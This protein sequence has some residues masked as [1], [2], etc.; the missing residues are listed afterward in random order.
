M[1]QV[2]TPEE[3]DPKILEYAAGQIVEIS[4]TLTRYQV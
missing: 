3:L 1:L 2:L 4:S